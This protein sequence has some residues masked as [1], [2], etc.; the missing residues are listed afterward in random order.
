MAKLL[1]KLYNRLIEGKLKIESS[2]DFSEVKKPKFTSTSLNSLTSEQV[3]S[4]KMGD[5]IDSGYTAFVSYEDES[6]KVISYLSYDENL[7]Y[8]YEYHFDS[9]TKKWIF[10]NLL[11][12]FISELV[13]VTRLSDEATN[14]GKFLQVQEDGTV[15]AATVS[16]GTKLYTHSFTSNNLNIVLISPLSEPVS[17]LVANDKINIIG[18]SLLGYNQKGCIYAQVVTVYNWPSSINYIKDLDDGE[19]NHTISFDTTS[20]AF[21]SVTDTVTPL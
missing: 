21:S 15:A 12:G 13:N 14:S 3:E 5:V 11:T 19:G 9:D 1:D 8:S 6:F 16:G 2:D 17:S 18:G 10:N 4:L 7:I 20:V